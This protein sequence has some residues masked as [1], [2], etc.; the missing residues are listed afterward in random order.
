L[1]P[2][3]GD[4]GAPQPRL[5]VEHER[6]ELVVVRRGQSHPRPFRAFMS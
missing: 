6:G 4:E 3:R 1:R 2:E 5:G